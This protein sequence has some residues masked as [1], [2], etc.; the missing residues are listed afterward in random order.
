MHSR[1]IPIQFQHKTKHIDK[2]NTLTRTP[3]DIDII[4]S[5]SSVENQRMQTCF[6]MEVCPIG[7]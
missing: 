3:W 7:M 1:I 6:E 5:V 2:E 4:L